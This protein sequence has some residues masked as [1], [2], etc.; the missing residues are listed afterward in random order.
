MQIYLLQNGQQEGPFGL[1]RIAAR[2]VSGDLNSATL[3]WK[4]GLQDWYPLHHE[5]WKEVGIVAPPPQAEPEPVAPVQEGPP[6]SVEAAPAVEPAV[7]FAEDQ[8]PAPAVEPQPEERDEQP[9]EALELDQP[10]EDESASNVE[11]NAPEA[12]SQEREQAPETSFANYRESDFQPPSYEQMEEEMAELRAKRGQ[13]PEWIGQRAFE[14]DLRDEEIDEVREKVQRFKGMGKEEELRA[15]YAELGRAVM[16]AGITDPALDDLRD[17]EQEVSDRML[18]LQM[19]LRRM[20]GGNRV[21]QPSPWRKWVVLLVVALVLGG[22]ITA[23][24]LF[25]NS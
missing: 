13:F 24:V 17:E 23:L 9:A 5:I 25:G 19:Q 20:G 1:P 2:L 22:L 8:E 14:A 18:N 12:V 21:K 7:P 3:A 15:A 11:E 4:E 16:A 10:L 6:A